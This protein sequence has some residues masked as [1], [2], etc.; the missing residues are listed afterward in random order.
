MSAPSFE[1]SPSKRKS[2]CEL[3]RYHHPPRLPFLPHRLSLPCLPPSCRYNALCD[4]PRFGWSH[5]ALRRF[6]V[7]P[8]RRFSH[9]GRPLQ[10]L[11][12]L[13]KITP[14]WPP[15]HFKCCLRPSGTLWDWRERR[16][17]TKCWRVP[18]RLGVSTTSCDTPGL[19]LIMCL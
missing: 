15:H 16:V 11:L 8:S 6:L 5:L 14:L 13:L 9:L 18:R 10:R 1:H 3:L 17:T 19:Q 2:C 12:H 7:R 4:D